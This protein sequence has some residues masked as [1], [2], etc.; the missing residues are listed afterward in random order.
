MAYISKP[1][2]R[3]PSLA[4]NAVG[5]TRDLRSEED[6]CDEAYEALPTSGRGVVV[7][8][9]LAH[10]RI[11]WGRACGKRDAAA[12]EQLGQ[13]ATPD[14]LSAYRMLTWRLTEAEV[15]LRAVAEYMLSPA[16][17]EVGATEA[18]LVAK[19][20][21]L[22]AG[23]LECS[24]CHEVEAGKAGTGPTLA[25]RGTP[26]WIARVT[27]NSAEPDLYGDRAEMPKFAVKLRAA[28]I[29][30]LAGFIAEQRKDTQ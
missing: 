14:G 9:A 3:H 28:Q 4:C 13:L 2:L 1:A 21:E 18:T 5:F 16:G 29:E 17:P 7:Q 22:W 30:A 8:S 6:L 20:K 23:K 12:W 15:D 27:R 10:A 19:G 11:A 25:G 26:A 24:G